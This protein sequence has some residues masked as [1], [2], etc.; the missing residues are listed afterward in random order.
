MIKASCFLLAAATVS[1]LASLP[2]AARDWDANKGKVVDAGCYA[3]VEGQILVDYEC[4][5]ILYSG[6]DFEVSQLNGN[7]FIGVEV[8]GEGL[9]KAHYRE[10]E[11]E[12]SMIEDLGA[13]RREKFD[14][15]CWAGEK[16]RIC[17]R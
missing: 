5:A 1:V 6:G 7:V 9:G 11:G 4:S 13:V 16:A 15:A 12:H 17:A 8:I 10:W 14:P 2:A 3:A